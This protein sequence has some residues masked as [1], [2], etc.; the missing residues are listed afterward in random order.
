MATIALSSRYGSKLA[1]DT[2]IWGESYRLFAAKLISWL[3]FWFVPKVV[4]SIGCVLGVILRAFRSV[5][6]GYTTNCLPFSG[7]S[8]PRLEVG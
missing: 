1:Y 3:V 5:F 6:K 8:E 2:G 4:F 7:I